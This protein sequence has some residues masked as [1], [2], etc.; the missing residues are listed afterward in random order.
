MVVWVAYSRTYRSETRID[1]ALRLI[2]LWFVALFISSIFGL[3]TGVVLLLVLPLQAIP[4]TGNISLS[5]LQVDGSRGAE[6]VGEDWLDEQPSRVGVDRTSVQSPNRVRPR[7][8][9][10]RST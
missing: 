8:E 9:S 1:A 10:S 7:L 4:A 5:G 3:G 2:G 6:I